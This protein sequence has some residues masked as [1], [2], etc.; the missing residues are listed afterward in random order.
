[1]EHLESQL[2]A[3]GVRLEEDVLDRV[4]EIVPPGVTIN[5]ADD[6]WPWN[7]WLSKDYLRSRS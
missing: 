4:D 2:E 5:P 1:M 7:P 6:G 3:V